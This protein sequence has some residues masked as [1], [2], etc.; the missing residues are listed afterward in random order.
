MFSRLIAVEAT[1]R[2]HAIP[3]FEDTGFRLNWRSLLIGLIGIVTLCLLLTVLSVMTVA[4]ASPIPRLLDLPQE[5]LPGHTPPESMS[6]DNSTS[7]VPRCFV[8]FQGHKAF[9]DFD[10]HGQMII[11]TIIPAERY[12]LGQLIVSWGEPAGIHRGQYMVY[13]NWPTRWVILDDLSL[14][15]NS[16]VRYILYTPELP[17]ASPWSDFGHDPD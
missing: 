12:R 11:R 1:P 8:D 14:R 6:C 16:P 4:R 17:P 15:P 10:R 2:P 3:I 5:F 7:S 13:V 9:F